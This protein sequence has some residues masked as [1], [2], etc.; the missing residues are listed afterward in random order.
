MSFELFSSDNE[1]TDRESDTPAI[2]T[3]ETLPKQ[4]SKSPLELIPIFPPL[5]PKELGLCIKAL[6]EKLKVSPKV[7][8]DNDDNLEEMVLQTFDG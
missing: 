8:I 7:T 1:V 4:V 5:T 2:L 3:K 6:K